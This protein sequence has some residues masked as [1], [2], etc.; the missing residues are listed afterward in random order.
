MIFKST[1]RV[2]PAS[3]VITV[4]NADLTAIDA[5]VSAEAEVVWHERIAIGLVDDVALEEGTLRGSRVGLLGLSD[6]D[7]LVLEV[8]IDGDL[9]DAEVLQ[10]TLDDV[11][12]EV[13]VESQDL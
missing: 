9:S 6:H 8:V 3:V 13:T 5:S 7:G 2:V 10:A 11:L 12:F 1:Y 4:I